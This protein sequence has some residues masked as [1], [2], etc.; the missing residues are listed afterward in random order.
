MRVGRFACHLKI[1]NCW[2]KC[3]LSDQLRFTAADIR[4]RTK[5]WVVDG[6][7]QTTFEVSLDGCDDIDEQL[8]EKVFKEI[9]GIHKLVDWEPVIECTNGDIVAVL[10]R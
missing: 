5:G 2:R 3:I 8:L 6:W 9:D 7:L 1:T 10:R 4:H